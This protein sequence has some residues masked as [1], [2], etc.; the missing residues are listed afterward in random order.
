MAVVQ[1]LFRVRGKREE[2]QPPSGDAG[3][4]EV[5]LEGAE[6]TASNRTLGVQARELDVEHGLSVRLIT[7]PRFCTFLPCM[8]VSSCSPAGPD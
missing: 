6:L 3:C 8:P 2:N 5:A 4:L 1:G 7:M